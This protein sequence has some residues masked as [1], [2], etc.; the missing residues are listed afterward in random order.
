[1]AENKFEAIVKLLEQRTSEGKLTWE[2]T[3]KEG[4]FQTSF[5]RQTITISED[6]NRYANYLIQIL[7]ERGRVVD[8]IRDNSTGGLERPVDTETFARLYSA[9]RHQAMRVDQT[10]DELLARLQQA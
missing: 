9:A 5:P 2:A 10:L 6:Q 3:A 1:M 8:E 4:V 7:D